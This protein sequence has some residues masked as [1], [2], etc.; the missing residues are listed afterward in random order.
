MQGAWRLSHRRPCRDLG[1]R[2][3]V[4][5][6]LDECLDYDCWTIHFCNGEGGTHSTLACQTKLQIA[7]S[8][9]KRRLDALCNKHNTRIALCP[10]EH[11]TTERGDSI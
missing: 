4:G 9:A 1:S 3:R 10:I 8:L 5:H 2:Q 6:R 7:F 11:A